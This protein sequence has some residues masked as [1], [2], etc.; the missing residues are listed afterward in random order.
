MRGLL[1]ELTATRV[2]IATRLGTVREVISRS[3]AHLQEKKL[4]SI[5]GR[6]VTVPSIAALRRFAT[7][8]KG[9]SLDP[10]LYT[11]VT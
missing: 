3:M 2:E 7:G 1:V 9:P 4:V 8:Q 5:R 6:L 10:A 11:S